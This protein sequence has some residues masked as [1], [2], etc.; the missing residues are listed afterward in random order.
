MFLFRQ[1]NFGHRGVVSSFFEYDSAMHQIMSRALN[2]TYRMVKVADGKYG[3][4]NPADGVTWNG[5]ESAITEIWGL[6][7]GYTILFAHYL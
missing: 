7:L 1:L 6:D 5:M 4:L 2:F 3:G